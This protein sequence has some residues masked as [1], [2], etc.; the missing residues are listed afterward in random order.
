MFLRAVRWHH[1]RPDQQQVARTPGER[2]FGDRSVV[3]PLRGTSMLSADELPF[4]AFSFLR[5]FV[6]RTRGAGKILRLDLLD[7]EL[8]Y[9][10][11]HRFKYI[12]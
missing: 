12:F 4:A 6:G 5:F 2:R 1:R 3:T 10:V 7:V 8:R 11:A 9:P